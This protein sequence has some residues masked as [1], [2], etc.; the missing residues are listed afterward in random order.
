MSTYGD[1]FFDKIGGSFDEEHH[2]PMAKKGQKVK[3]DDDEL[4]QE[5]EDEMN[6]IDERKEEMEALHDSHPSVKQLQ[7]ELEKV[8]TTLGESKDQL[9]RAHAEM[10]NLRRRARIDVENAHKYGLEK[11]VKSLLPVVD[12]LE[13]A[14]EAGEK[15]ES[16]QAHAEGVELTLKMFLDVLKKFDVN[17]IDPEGEPFNPDQHEAVSMLPNPEVE[18]NTVIQVLQKGYELNGRLIRPAMVIVSK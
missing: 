1:N 9:L 12:S 8:K 5:L 18:P 14:L 11:F 10:D 13:K 6:D 7:E 15:H 16:A 4:A 2:E 17:V 3:V